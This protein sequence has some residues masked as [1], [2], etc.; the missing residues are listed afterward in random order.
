METSGSENLSGGCT[1][2]TPSNPPPRLKRVKAKEMLAYFRMKKA[3]QASELLCHENHE[4][5]LNVSDNLVTVSDK[6]KDKTMGRFRPPLST[7]GGPKS[8]R[9][10]PMKPRRKNINISSK[11]TKYFQPVV[12]EK[13]VKNTQKGQL[14]NSCL[15]EMFNPSTS[16]QN[17]TLV[18]VKE[19]AKRA[20][21]QSGGSICLKFSKHK[22]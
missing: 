20:S 7:N 13:F 10:I 21:S 15:Q 18:R 22:G 8:S 1:D 19:P 2:P 11:I 6:D 4:N 16:R 9:V 17:E 3:G 5:L 14:I 12:Q